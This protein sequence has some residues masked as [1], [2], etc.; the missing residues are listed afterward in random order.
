L[1]Q[2]DAPRT[3]P[4]ELPSTD[5]SCFATPCGLLVNELQTNAAH[6][7]EC[8]IQL[9]HHTIELDAGRFGPGAPHA[10]LYVVRLL[11][12][13]EGHVLL[14]LSKERSTRGTLPSSGALK[15]RPQS[16]TARP[17]GLTVR[18]EARSH[19]SSP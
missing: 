10:M 2:P 6:V 12:R 8:L 17:R 7:L 11:V 14:V 4:Q 19:V 9:G 13:V 18:C 1:W 16:S 5:R 3:P 15:A